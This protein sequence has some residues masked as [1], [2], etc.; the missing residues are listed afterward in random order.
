LGKALSWGYTAAI[1]PDDFERWRSP[2]PARVS[3]SVAFEDEARMRQ[4]DGECRHF[5]IRQVPLRDDSGS[6]VKW[7]GAA[8]DIEDRK[9]AEEL[10]AELARVARLTTMAELRRSDR[11]DSASTR[12]A[13]RVSRCRI[14]SR[15]IWRE[16]TW[17]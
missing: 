16:F 2:R 7:Y 6:I 8:T 5:L 1:P 15:P 9:R 17:R 4:V 10:Q 13:A 3:A 11:P 14:F 12:R